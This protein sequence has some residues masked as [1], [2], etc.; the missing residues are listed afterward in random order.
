MR[1]F[2]AFLIFNGILIFKGTMPRFNDILCP[3][4]RFSSTDIAVSTSTVV[5]FFIGRQEIKPGE[6]LSN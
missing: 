1:L 4:G 2:K 3:D 5:L 6:V